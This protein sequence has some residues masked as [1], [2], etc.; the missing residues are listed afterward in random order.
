MIYVAE[1]L[2]L[3]PEVADPLAVMFGVG[4]TIPSH[5]IFTTVPSVRRGVVSR[6]LEARWDEV[7]VNANGGGLDKLPPTPPP[8]LDGALV[9]GRHRV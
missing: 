2:Y 8:P 3:T 1:Q 4:F 6:S 9:G 7:H 5:F